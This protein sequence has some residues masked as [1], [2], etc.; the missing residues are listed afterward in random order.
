MGGR[1]CCTAAMR[2]AVA[3][4]KGSDDLQVFVKAPSSLLVRGPQ[5]QED[6][7]ELADAEVEN[8]QRNEGNGG[9]GAHK[10]KDRREDG[11]EGTVGPHEEAQ[12]DPDRETQPQAGKRAGEA[13]E[14]VLAERLLGIPLGEERQKLADQVGRGG[15][16]EGLDDSEGRQP[17]PEKEEARNATPRQEGIAPPL[18]ADQPSGTTV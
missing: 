9:N 17:V 13:R 8:H 18:H 15:K 2:H 14:D 7:G 3:S 16:H 12:R 10:G 4:P 1:G 11:E 5:D 6:F